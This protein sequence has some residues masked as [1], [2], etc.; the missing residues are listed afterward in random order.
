MKAQ[1]APIPAKDFTA[2]LAAAGFRAFP[3]IHGEPGEEVHELAH[4]RDPRYVV[5]V[6]ST[7]QRD[8]ATVRERGEGSVSVVALRMPPDAD[9]VFNGPAINR[10]GTVEEFL[11]RVIEGAREAYAA[12]NR[13][14][15][16]ADLHAQAQEVSVRSKVSASRRRE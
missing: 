12:I 15:L 16:T 8:E 2:R 4:H 13:R 14:R 1:F 9:V 5:R 11:D 10:A 3:V 6:H 7:L